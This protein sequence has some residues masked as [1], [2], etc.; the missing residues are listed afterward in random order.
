MNGKMTCINQMYYI[1]SDM[2]V[3]F[4]G[5]G[6]NNII[7]WRRQKYEIKRNVQPPHAP[8]I[9]CVQSLKV[10]FIRLNVFAK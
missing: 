6:P 2:C 1:L 5:E 7:C 8:Q 9:I 4:Q 10:P 3:G